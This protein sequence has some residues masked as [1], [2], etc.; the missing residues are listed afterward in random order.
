MAL[1]LT[2]SSLKKTIVRP[3]PS[4]LLNCFSHSLLCTCFTKDLICRYRHLVRQTTKFLRPWVW[5]LFFIFQALI[6]G[7]SMAGYLKF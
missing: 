1:S 5:F 2:F 3:F 4:S 7:L 6:Q